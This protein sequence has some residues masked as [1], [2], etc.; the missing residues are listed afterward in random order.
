MSFIEYNSRV[1]IGNHRVSSSIW[2]KFCSEFFKN[3]KLHEPL[4]RVQF[5][6]LEKLASANEFQIEREKPYDYLLIIQT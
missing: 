5:Q 3:L 1:S 4:R 2:N 6:L